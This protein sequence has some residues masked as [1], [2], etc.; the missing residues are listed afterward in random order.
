[1]WNPLSRREFIK[2]AAGGA[3]AIGLGFTAG[4]QEENLE[5]GLTVISGNTRERGRMYGAAFKDA[6][7][8]FLN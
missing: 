7:H 1:M 6:I 5:H 2:R 8:A 3:A 4:A